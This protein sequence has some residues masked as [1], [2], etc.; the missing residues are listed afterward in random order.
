MRVAFDTSS[1]RGRK[2]GIGYYTENLICA[3]RKFAPDVEVVEMADPAAADQRTPLRILREQFAIPRLASRAGADI[4]HLTGFA[5]PWRA[6]CPVVLNAHDLAGKLFP[7]NFPP[8]SRFYWS[9]YLPFTLR[10]PD[11]LVV[12]SESAKNDLVKLEM[13]DANR[14]DVIPPG[15]DESFRPVNDAGALEKVRARLGLPPAFILFVSTLEPRKG[16]DTLLSAYA[17]VAGTISDDLVIVGRRGWYWQSLNKQVKEE[18]LEGRVHFMEYVPKDDLAIV[19]NLARAFVFPS[20]YEGFGLTPLEAMA[21]GTPVICS[22]ASSLT[23]VVGDAAVRVP[24]EDHEGFAGAIAQVTGDSG[25]RK[26]MRSRG[27]RQAALFT[28]QRTARA[29]AEVYESLYKVR[30]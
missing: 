4:L 27:L 28:W 21:C 17:R 16:V 19:Y 29:T 13:V 3:L 23:E 8:I 25:L 14:I 7:G 9:R 18:G 6:P 1:T 24:P 30:R 20:R 26:E 11:R 2:T 15:R 22:N 12:L 5:A 10:F